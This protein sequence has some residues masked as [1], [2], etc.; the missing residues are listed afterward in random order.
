MRRWSLGFAITGFVI[1]TLMT[2]TLIVLWNVYIIQ[3]YRTIHELTVALQN[4]RQSS[5]TTAHSPGQR[6][7]VLVM[8]SI[9]LT[10]ILVALSLFFAAYL[11]A[12]SFRAR[13]T[14]WLNQ[15]TH[16]LKMPLANILMFTQ[17]LQKG[18]TDP[19]ETQAFLG[20][21]LQETRRLQSLV[22]RILQ[23]RRVDAL[24]RNFETLPIEAGAW[25]TDLCQA[26]AFPITWNPPEHEIWIMG[27]RTL[28]DAALEN[29]LSNAVKY[30]DRTPP[31]LFLS[32][33]GNQIL[34]EVA[35]R[36]IGIPVRYRKH[37][38]SRFYR[39]PLP[40]HRRREGT[41]LGLH[42]ARTIIRH[43]KGDIGIRS[44]DDGDGSVFWIRLPQKGD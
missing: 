38:F 1:A 10:A 29:I 7:A 41:G 16:E 35:D 14:E 20:L 24:N 6:W 26:Q 30:G 43:H 40:E 2:V 13:Q 3:D 23:A 36:G 21:V 28:L 39:A 5:S 11:G 27:E 18:Q 32:P 9:F 33:E 34:I 31:E 42:I 22:N 12:R 25:L 17:T 37:I 15:T 8:G 19:Q 44:R 4:M